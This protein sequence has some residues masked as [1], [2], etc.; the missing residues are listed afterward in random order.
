MAYVT[1]HSPLFFEYL[2]LL[3]SGLEP[4]PEW[5]A[6]TEDDALLVIDMQADFIMSDKTSNPHGG[7]FGV[8][9]AENII[10]PICAMM[11]H[12]AE[13]G[14]TVVACRDYH[15]HGHVCFT[16]QGGHLPPHCLEGS[17]GS[18]LIGP[19]AATMHAL[20]HRIGPSRAFIAFKGMHEDLDSFGAFAYATEYA[21]TRLAMREPTSNLLCSPCTPDNVIRPQSAELLAA[22]APPR[23]L[24]ALGTAGAP[25]APPTAFEFATASACSLTPW[26]GCLVL[27]Q[28]AILHAYA[29][30]E[31]ADMNV[32]RVCLVAYIGVES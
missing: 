24:P 15:P 20:L 2:S 9:E 18:H 8:A 6:I 17:R 27:K 16:D 21:S 13:S 10:D 12:F 30:G 4:E 5:G 1:E 11:E 23:R 22:G 25:P 28:S 14:A 26:T 32:R 29:H 19:I 31:E 7:R 3:G